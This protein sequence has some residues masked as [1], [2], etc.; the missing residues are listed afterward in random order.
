MKLIWYPVII[1]LLIA[2]AIFL[3]KRFTPPQPASLETTNQSQNNSTLPTGWKIITKQTDY[4][5]LEKETDRGVKPTIVF[6]TSP[7]KT[8]LSAE[9]YLYRLL[10]SLKYTLPSF[11]LESSQITSVNSAT[12]LDYTATYT[13]TSQKI[14]IIQKSVLKDNQLETYTFSSSFANRSSLEAEGRLLLTQVTTG[15]I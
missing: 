7:I 4:I 2:S 14:L 10:S 3:T 15:S 8:N 6:R 11:K 5:K 13:N 1:L 12:V 9:K